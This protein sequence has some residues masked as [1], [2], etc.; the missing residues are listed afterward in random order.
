MTVADEQVLTEAGEAPS[1]PPDPPRQAAIP[2]RSEPEVRRLDPRFVAQQRVVGW[3]VSAILSL[4]ILVSAA[5]LLLAAD[6][7]GLVRVLLAPGA[8]LVTAGIAWLFHVW[9]GVHYRHVSY[10]VSDDGV[11]IRTGVWWREVLS[12]PRSRVQ[13]I[14]VSQGPLERAFG[15]GRL[16]V[17]TAGTNHARVELPGLAHGVALE[18]RDHL[19][20]RGGDDAV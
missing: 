5:V 20:P 16:V 7:P 2:T 12:V 14:D 17:Y 4:T 19:M 6:L 13:H 8:L 9:P 15:L 18:L 11:E 10:L 3:I 1:I